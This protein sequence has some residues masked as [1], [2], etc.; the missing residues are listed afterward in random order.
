MGKLGR[1]SALVL[2]SLVRT[3]LE[4]SDFR[5]SQGALH[6]GCTTSHSPWREPPR[7]KG[8]NRESLRWEAVAAAGK[9]RGEHSLHLL[10]WQPGE[11]TIIDTYNRESQRQSAS[12]K[13]D[14]SLEW[15]G[16]QRQINL[17][18]PSSLHPPL[19]CFGQASQP[20]GYP[21]GE[22]LG[23]SVRVSRR[24]GGLSA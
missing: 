7:R 20:S 9:L 22:R 2:P 4:A 19:S 16:Y 23:H 10:P 18:F 11:S 14:L 1:L 6:T 15:D 17:F 24:P 3:A 5:H 13:W 8:N 12:Q 21:D